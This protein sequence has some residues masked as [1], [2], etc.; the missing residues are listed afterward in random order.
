MS[1][2]SYDDL[3]DF[4]DD[5][6]LDD[7]DEDYDTEE[8]DEM[9]DALVD[10]D[11]DEDMAERL[12][13]RKARRRARAKSKR[14]PVPTAAGRPA[15][16]PPVMPGFVTQ[17]QLQDAL[18]RVGA[19]VKR[20]VAGIK[21]VNARLNGL[22]G[23]VDGVVSVNAVQSR[24]LGKLDRQMKIAGA[25]EIVQALEPGR[26][27]AFQLLKGAAASGFIGDGKGA[28]SNPWVIGGL[29]MLLRNPGFLG[30]LT[31]QA[32]PQPTTVNIP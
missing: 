9:L 7:A 16:R 8:I 29:G 2:S 14:K 15:Y 18:G 24:A 1:T 32:A 10:S 17:K 25:L 21:T 23:R 11:G 20:N 27:D 13:R 6:E 26:L 3:I 30:G 19:D 22:N 28:L 31:Q 5:I 4:D 12:F